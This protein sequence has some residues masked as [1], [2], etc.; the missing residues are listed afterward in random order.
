MAAL[1]TVE[2]P[3]VGLK[4]RGCHFRHINHFLQGPGLS[5]SNLDNT[6]DF[7]FLSVIVTVDHRLSV[8]MSALVLVYRGRREKWLKESEGGREFEGGFLEVVKL[9]NE[10]TS[11]R[12]NR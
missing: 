11:F 9:D 2:N 10:Q 7:F 8:S 3:G 1:D 5:D 4:A 12:G 6:R